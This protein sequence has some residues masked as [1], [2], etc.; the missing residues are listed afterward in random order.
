MGKSSQIPRFVDARAETARLP[1]AK[2]ARFGLRLVP[3]CS[4]HF[5][6]FSRPGFRGYRFAAKRLI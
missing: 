5:F 1:L 4:G 2:A 6:G 3:A